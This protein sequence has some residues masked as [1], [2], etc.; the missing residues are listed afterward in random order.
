MNFNELKDYD[1]MMRID[2]DS[3]FKKPIKYD[4]FE[5]LDKSNKLCGCAY[6]WNHV[7]HRVLDTRMT[8][9]NWIKQYVSKYN[10]D[11]KNKTLKKCLEEGENDIIDNRKCNRKFHEMKQLCGNFNIYD[12]KMFDLKEWKQ[13]LKEFNDFGGGFKLRWG[14]CEVISLFY[15]IHIGESFLDL[16]LKNKGIYLNQLPNVTMIKNGLE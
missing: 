4:M 11:V 1:Y 15:Y 5:E 7:H 10:I 16:D 8:F 6:T 13:Y 14:D 9:Y 2:D 12:R 3:W